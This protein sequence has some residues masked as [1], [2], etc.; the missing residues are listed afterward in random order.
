MVEVRQFFPNHFDHNHPPPQKKNTNY[1]KFTKIIG[2][3]EKHGNVS[4]MDLP[5]KRGSRKEI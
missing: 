4:S 5:E 2:A 1:K 3:A